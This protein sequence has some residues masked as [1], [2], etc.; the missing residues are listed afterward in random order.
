MPHATLASLI[1]RY[2]ADMLVDLTDRAMPPAG[3]IDAGVVEAAIED[4]DA[5]VDG[6]LAGRYRLPL[7]GTPRLVQTLAEALAIYKLHA[8]VAPEKIEKDYRDAL[9]L[10][11]SIA[12]G[13][14]RLAGLDG[15]E[16]AASGGNGVRTTDRARPLTPENLKGFA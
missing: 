7:S 3:E 15:A 1:A 4:A 12:S 13:D 14:V 10:L 5:I 8:Q 6:Y 16:P 9:K 11:G 2:G